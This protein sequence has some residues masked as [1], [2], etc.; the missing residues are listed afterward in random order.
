[1]PHRSPALRSLLILLASSALGGC[2]ADAALIATPATPPDPEP[3][4]TVLNVAGSAPDAVV[5]LAP[6][7]CDQGIEVHLGGRRYCLYNSTSTWPGAEARC[8][9][10][11]GHLATIA[12]SDLGSLLL[13]TVG[14]PPG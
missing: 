1:V 5:A 3:R 8:I 11:G 7:D 12:T 6:F 10:H 4:I 9:E 2:G 13:Q 14:F